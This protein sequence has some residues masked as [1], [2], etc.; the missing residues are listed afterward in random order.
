MQSKLLN[1]DP[2]DPLYGTPYRSMD[3]LGEGG[4]G[5]VVEA[6]HIGL[7]TRVAVKLLHGPLAGDP[8]V[9]TR[10]RLEAQAQALIDHPG[11]TRATDFGRTATGN[12][13]LV[14]EL[15]RGRTLKTLL[16]ERG[17]LSVRESV[18]YV[19]QAL[20]ALA[21]A[22]AA[23]IVHRDVKLA[24][25]FVLDEP[26]DTVKLLD[27][28]V[29]KALAGAL[30]VARGGPPTAE[31]VVVGTPRYCAPEQI[32][33][34][35]IDQRV[36]LYALGVCLYELLVGHD[37]FVEYDGAE[38]M[39]LAHLR[40]PPRPP[41]TLAAQPI[42]AELDAIVLRALAKDRDQRFA[43]AHAMVE[44]LERVVATMGDA[45]S[46]QRRSR[47]PVTEPLAAL[48]SRLDAP[49]T[50]I[51]ERTEPLLLARRARKPLRQPDARDESGTVYL[52]TLLAE[53]QPAVSEPCP[54]TTREAVP[55]MRPTREPVGGCYPRVALGRPRR[56]LRLLGL[57]LVIAALAA[58]AVLLSRC[59]TLTPGPAALRSLDAATSL[60]P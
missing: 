56:G 30:V 43:S 57:A 48:P 35:M 25:L 51:V 15:L 7:R 8:S 49:T 3:E 60:R 42:P 36:D 24:N 21:A 1:G 5:R 13:Y 29:A 22:H 31:G 32:R 59:S 50:P 38:S 45:P 20:T 41:S 34:Q 37:P 11:I 39:M 19:L 23:G 6:E 10:L 17:Y 53:L 9:V 55:T 40:V 18:S 33:A 44:A 4:M 52:G 28:G 26:A 12:A 47:W 14:T 2:L 46:P 58:A 16:G 54:G 27:F